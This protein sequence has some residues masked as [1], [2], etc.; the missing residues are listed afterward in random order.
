MSRTE[1]PHVD[2]LV[3]EIDAPGVLE[4]RVRHDGRGRRGRAWRRRL[5]RGFLGDLALPD[6]AVLVSE[7]AFDD[8]TERAIAA[9]VVAMVAGVDQHVDAPG[10]R[11][12]VM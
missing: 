1:V 9:R 2:L 11:N 5:R 3:A 4:R 8:R 6:D 7:H 12:R 10:T